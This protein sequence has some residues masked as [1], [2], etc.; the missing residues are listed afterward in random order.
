MK[1]IIVLAITLLSV[2]ACDKLE[3]NEYQI[4]GSAKG[5]EDGKQLFI[6]VRGEEALVNQD[7]VTV[8]DGKFTVKGKIENP[9][10][11]FLTIEQGNGVPFILQEGKITLNINKDTL[12][13]SII[14]GTEE[15]EIFQKYTD[16]S[17]KVYKKI[18]AH[19]DANM[20]KFRTAEA[21]NDTV[22]MTELE[23]KMT[24]LQS[25]LKNLP[26]EF[27]EK[28]PKNFVS[29]ILLENM[30]MNNFVTPEEAKAKFEVL[31]NNYPNSK[32]NQNI[33]KM[34]E[35]VGA[36][37]VGSKAPDFSGPSP[38]GKTISLKESLG[39]VTIIDFWASWCGP[40]RVENPNVVAMYN[41]LH[42]QGLNIIGVSL[43]KDANKWV[44]AIE[45]DKLTWSHV[46]NLKQWEDP[47]AQMYGIQSIPATIILDTNGT[48][49]AKDLR[50]EELKAKVK[51]LLAK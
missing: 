31:K 35:K 27:I 44:E 43:D 21:V 49:V 33:T 32:P 40:C 18:T 46:S 42:A 34:L 37:T 26:L 47:I 3:K 2:V 22:T 15:N 45:K 14:G 28:Y 23:T 41:E 50:G 39:K 7:T 24:E 51:E 30:M 11:A 19:R 38:D 25:G 8:R 36:I 29:I 5:F 17:K 1:K 10:L 12:Q 48:I 16:E 13:N 20:E 6:Q 4:E 9:D